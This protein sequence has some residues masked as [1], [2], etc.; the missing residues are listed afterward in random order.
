VTAADI[1]GIEPV[2]QLS[3]LIKQFMHLSQGVS[4]LLATCFTVAG[5]S[6]PKER[7]SPANSF[8]KAH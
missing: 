7:T 1:S 3:L 6:I 5:I 2:R 4:C 8:N